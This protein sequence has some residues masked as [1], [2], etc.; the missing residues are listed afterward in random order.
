MWPWPSI[1][2][3]KRMF[4]NPWQRPTHMMELSDLQATLDE[5]ADRLV[6]S[7]MVFPAGTAD[8]SGG[9]HGGG[10]S[11]TGAGGGEIGG[12]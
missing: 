4:R 7:H 6:F 1:G 5:E 8:P 3:L 2:F 11:G 9:C 10:G 12:Q